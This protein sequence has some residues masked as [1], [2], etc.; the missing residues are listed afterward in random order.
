MLAKW[1]KF[2]KLENIFSI[3]EQFLTERAK[4][5]EV[6]ARNLANVDTPGYKAKD[7]DFTSIYQS[8]VNQPLA[9]T[10]AKHLNTTSTNSG[11]LVE[12]NDAGPDKFDGNTVD[13][14]KEVAKFTENAI[15]YRASLTF[16]NGQ[17]RGV[18]TALKG[19]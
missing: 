16:I 8:Q 4:R 12:T 13:S 15:K 5:A 11:L 2:M 14:Q 10:H 7:I 3:H 9:T 17:I 6:I 1:W 19:E 18:L